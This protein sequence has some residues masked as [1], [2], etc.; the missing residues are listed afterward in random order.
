LTPGAI[1]RNPRTK[2]KLSKNVFAVTYI[3]F[4]IGR[5]WPRLIQPLAQSLIGSPGTLDVVDEIYLIK[6]KAV[7]GVLTAVFLVLANLQT[8]TDILILPSRYEHLQ[9]SID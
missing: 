5:D 1:L 4:I 3:A 9:Q 7:V 8:M 6:L 2:C